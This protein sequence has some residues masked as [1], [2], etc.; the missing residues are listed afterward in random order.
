M[1]LPLIFLLSQ[2]SSVYKYLVNKTDIEDLQ[3]KSTH[4][5]EVFYRGRTRQRS[6]YERTGQNMFS[7][8]LETNYVITYINLTVYIGYCSG[9]RR[10]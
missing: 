1:S 5:N 9:G 4:E 6:C 10:E 2:G 3:N 7:F 8:D